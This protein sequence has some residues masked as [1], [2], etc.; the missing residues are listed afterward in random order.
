MANTNTVLIPKV[1]YRGLMALRQRV[2]MPRLVNSDFSND[3]VA[4]GTQIVIPLP[5]AVADQAV[6]PSNVLVAPTDV[7]LTS[8]T[9]ALDQWRHSKP[10]GLTDK[11]KTEIDA[12]ANFLPMQMSEAIKGLANTLNAYIW[13]KYTTSTSGVYGFIS[14]PS[15][16]AASAIIDPFASGTTDTSGVSAATNAKRVLNAQLC[17]RQDRRGVL[18]FNAEAAMLDLGAISDAEKI[19]SPD[20]KIEGEI[21]RKFGI[22]WFADDHVPSHTV[23]TCFASTPADVT[24]KESEAKGSTAISILDA[25]AGTLVA[26]D[27]FTIAGD[28]QTYVVT[29]SSAPYTLHASNDTQV[30]ILPHLKVAVSGGGQVITVKNSHVVN[31]VFHRDAF[32]FAMRVLEMDVTGRQVMTMTDPVSGITL[33][34]MVTPQHYQTTWSFDILYGAA[35]VRPEFA[36]RIAG[37]I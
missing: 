13:G 24:C 8:A 35:L 32:G 2:I 20:V 29:G 6:T 11:E 33:R 3:A 31:M 19:G 14:N 7:T 22:D 30:S 17:P 5:V 21:G 16:G 37:A 36:M 9:L 15:A 18:N 34:L 12:D 23:G 27:I 28:S 25:G 26:G 10:V 4:K 1:L